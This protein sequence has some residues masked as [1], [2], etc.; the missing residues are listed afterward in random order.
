MTGRKGATRRS[1]IPPEILA[2]LNAGEME[3]AT[4]AEMLAIDF[5]VLIR[6]FLPSETDVS[7][8]SGETSVTKRMAIAAE[9]LLSHRGATVFP[10]LT[11]HPADTVRGWAAFLVGKLPQ[12][13]L[14]EQLEQIRPLADDSHFG[15]REWAWLALRGQV[16]HALMEAIALLSPWTQQASPNLRRFAS[17]ITRPRGVWCNHIKQ[18]KDE[19]E[20]GL[21]ILEPLRADPAVYV[22]DSVANW[23]NDAAKTR[24]EWVRSVCSRWLIESDT[25]Q[26]HRIC[27]RGLRNA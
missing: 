3:T 6:P 18:L 23:L 27:K 21:P 15:V 1:D 12:Q 4:L 20:P 13:T 7:Q 14:A 25:P 26:T 8:L 11:Q 19:P 5:T 16:S 17:E 2:A 9:L 10:E 22:Q 24:P